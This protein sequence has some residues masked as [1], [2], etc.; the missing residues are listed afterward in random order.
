MCIIIDAD[1]LGLVFNPET[2]EHKKFKPVLEWINNGKGKIVYGGTKYE[3]E[4]IN[5]KNAI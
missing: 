4:L 1:T 2:K 5:A 3:K